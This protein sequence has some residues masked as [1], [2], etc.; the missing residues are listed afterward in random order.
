MATDLPIRIPSLPMGKITEQD[1]IPT[2]D[3]LTF[4]QGLIGN[5]QRL[6]GSEGVVLPSLTTTQ[7]DAIVANQNAQNQYTC[8][9]GTMFYDTVLKQIWATV[10]DP[11]ITGKPIKKL[12]V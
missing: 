6:F 5:L 11:A 9:F 10:E 4:R 2:D 7:I 1:G 12:I 3:E 8:A